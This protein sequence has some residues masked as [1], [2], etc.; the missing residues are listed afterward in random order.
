MTM[1]LSSCSKN[2]DESMSDKQESRLVINGNCD[3]HTLEN[4][5]SASWRV[6]ESP[7]W[8]T[9]VKTEGS[10]DDKVKI[11]VESN[12][13]SLR[14]GTVKIKY[15]NGKSRSIAVV[16]SANKSPSSLQRTYAA[17]WSFDVRT[18]MDLRGLKDQI[19]N[20]Q[21]LLNYDTINPLYV[22]EDNQSTLI[23][24]YYGESGSDL[25]DD[26]SGK[27][28]INGKYNT[29]S[30][31]LQA[32]FGK[33][34]ISNSKRIF[35]RIRSRYQQ[36]VVYLNQ[37]D[38]S[39]VQSE[40]LFTVDFAAERKKV[41]D[42]G[43]SDESIRNLIERYGTHLVVLANLGGCY[44]YFYSSVVENNNNS[45]NV[46]G[47][48]KLGFSEKFKLQGDVNYKDDLKK[49]SSETIEKFTVK[50]GDAIMLSMAVE[51]DTITET[52]TDKWLATLRDE[53]KYELLS[54]QLVP[55]SKLFPL[56]E[57]IKINNYTERMYYSEIPVTRS[58]N[59]LK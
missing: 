31:D 17:G 7:A 28:G 9:P 8:V 49:L 54:F 53:K 11:Y 1:N 36:C 10:A 47:A 4:M 5:A 32:S 37:L 18:Y 20:A 34:A 58:A 55:I 27:L 19:F 42:A 26:M 13:A 44:D 41:I 39:E 15:S 30:L 14:E 38:Y 23:D 57:Q 43:A 40:D 50:G 6:A 3:I 45:L 29:F 46:E 52:T 12:S 48:I 2:D 51:A 16:Q 35:S 21:K 59:Y 25:S 24:Y 56:T 33:S 22:I